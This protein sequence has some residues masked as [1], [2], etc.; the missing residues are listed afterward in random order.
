MNSFYCLVGC[1]EKEKHVEAGTE[2]KAKV[3]KNSV[4][5]LLLCS[6][7][8]TLSTKRILGITLMTAFRCELKIILT[9]DRRNLLYLYKDRKVSAVLRLEQYV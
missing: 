6:L 3:R 2:S 8:P 4:L 9:M 5:S 1:V 7:S